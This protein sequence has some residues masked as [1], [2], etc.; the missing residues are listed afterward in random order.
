MIFKKWS[1]VIISKNTNI[2]EADLIYDLF[3]RCQ[4]GDKSVLNYLFKMQNEKI[5]RVDKLSEEYRMK[6][7]DSTLNPEMK[8]LHWQFEKEDR[9]TDLNSDNITFNY[10]ILNKMLRNMKKA[11]SKNSLETGFE[12]GVKKEHQTYKKY[13]GGEYDITEFAEIMYEVIITI[14]L[15]ELDGNGCVTFNGKKNKEVPIIDGI[16]L[17]KNI[18]Y[19]CCIQANEGQSKR[20][21]DISG[22]EDRENDFQS[23]HINIF[24][25]YSFEKWQ[26]EEDEK[27]DEPEEVFR[28]WVYADVLDWLRKHKNNI[29]NLFK[30]NSTEIQAIIN[31]ILSNEKVFENEINGCLK[32]VKQKEL[33]QLIYEQTGK[34]IVLTNIST[35]LKLIEQ[36]IIDH[37][38]YSMNYNI[39]DDKKEQAIN[40][41]YLQELDKKSYFKLFGR[42]SM[43]IFKICSLCLDDM[44]KEKF[45]DHIREHDDAVIPILSLVKGR[46][47]YD[48]I[49]L[50]RC[51]L[52][53][54]DDDTSY[55]QI[56]LNVAQ[57]LIHYYQEVEAAK[58]A[59]LKRQYVFTDRFTSGKSQMWEADLLADFLRIRFWADENT[60]HSVGYKINK[61]NLLIYEGY[62]NFYFCDESEMICFFMP[63]G[64]RVITRSDSLHN[65]FFSKIA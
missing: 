20:F 36:R 63:K 53:V 56:V 15:G 50:I 47:K 27:W 45:L 55:D 17:L 51:D 12:N 18:S 5:S 42:E 59:E 29:M 9:E 3:L 4:A 16:T 33:Q 10:S 32:L 34:W 13:Y 30:K 8:K 52:D 58:I 43:F 46:R 39:G 49:N 2:E 41:G 64:K 37:L 22:A 7:L 62:E 35:D 14:F 19:F 48:M 60:K 23:E 1:V 57:T 65:I 21:N 25:S 31:I 61:D 11:Y 28:L 24:D 26:H 40:S 6:S 38:F 44:Y 54:I